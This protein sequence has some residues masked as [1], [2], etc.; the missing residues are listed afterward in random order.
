MTFCNIAKLG[1]RINFGISLDPFLLKNISFH[2]K[3]AYTE[4]LLKTERKEFE[5]PEFPQKKISLLS[6]YYYELVHSH[7]SF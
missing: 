4:S 3:R 7:T 2:K 5:V 6:V 1:I